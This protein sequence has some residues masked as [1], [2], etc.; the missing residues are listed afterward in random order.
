[1]EIHAIETGFFST[2]GG[3]MFGIVSKKVWSRQYPSDHENRCPLAMRVL[4]ADM[5]NRK[6][7]FDTGVG[8]QLAEG[9]S[10]YRFHSLK[11]VVEE[12]KQNG[13]SPDAVTDVVLSHLHFD[14]CGGSV[15]VRNGS[16]VPAFP[17]AVY[18]VGEKQRQAALH[19]SLWEADSFAPQVVTTLENAGQLCVV[20]SDRE[21]FPGVRVKLMQGHTDDQ[22]LSYIDTSSG[23]VVFCGDVIPLSLHVMPL[24]VAAVDNAPVHSVDEKMKVLCEA[25]EKNQRLFFFHDAAI[26]AVS[27]RLSNGRISVKEKYFF[28]Q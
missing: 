23:T 4:Y 12:L 20:G 3:A 21:L 5:G 28:T 16:L 2:D 18:W 7:L 13:Y 22:L 25:V 11:D 17:N 14:H 26:H 1:M 15:A 10:Y 24:C 27:L 8:A 6:V 9:A 19:P